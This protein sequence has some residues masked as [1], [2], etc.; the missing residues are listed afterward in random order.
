MA[1]LFGRA[2]DTCRRTDTEQSIGALRAACRIVRTELGGLPSRCQ[3]LRP[4][5]VVVDQQVDESMRRIATKV[6]QIS[7]ALR[8]GV[9]P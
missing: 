6:D 2:A 8:P 4:V 1:R 3:A 9:A 7:A 5:A